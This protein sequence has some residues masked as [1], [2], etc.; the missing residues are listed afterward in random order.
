M[1][2][3]VE[4]RG[5]QMNEQESSGTGSKNSMKLVYAIHPSG[6]EIIFLTPERAAFICRIQE[7]L[8]NSRTWHEFRLAMPPGEYDT[9]MRGQFDD[10]D[11]PRPK[12]T[13]AF[14]CDDIQIVADR[15]YPEW[16]QQEMLS[17]DAF[18]A[19]LREK[20]GT[21]EESV[22]DGLFLSIDVSYLDEILKELARR[23]Y[24]VEDGDNMHLFMW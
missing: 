18:P 1:L 23:G 11:E 4:M 3:E 16:V 7:A 5:D 21:V 14:D 24:H 6:E 12:G 9:I 22:L 8:H 19:D 13:D 10:N 17:D 15:D 20:Y 2:H